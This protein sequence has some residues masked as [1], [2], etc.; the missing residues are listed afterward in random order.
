MDALA[1][2]QVGGD[3]LVVSESFRMVVL[4]NP[5]GWPFQGNDFYRECGDV[6]AAHVIDNPDAASELALVRA[7]APRAAARAPRALVGAFGRL[8]ALADAGALS[9]PYSTREL[10]K[11]AKLTKLETFYLSKNSLSGTLPQWLA[12]LTHLQVLCAPSLTTPLRPPATPAYSALCVRRVHVGRPLN[13][14]PL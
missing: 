13:Q 12:E 3:V 6:L 9:Y 7:L 10:V 11:L 8:R 2:T 14:G 1:D 4:A 5:P